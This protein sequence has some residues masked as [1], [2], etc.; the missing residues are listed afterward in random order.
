MYALDRKAH[1]TYKKLTIKA[2]NVKLCGICSLHPISR[3]TTLLTGV[4][5]VV[6]PF[7]VDRYYCS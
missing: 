6:A 2:K 3:T 7:F 1:P 4:E 5:S